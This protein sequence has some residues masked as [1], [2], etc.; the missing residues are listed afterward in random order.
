MDMTTYTKKDM[1]TAA[2][3]PR[4]DQSSKKDTREGS[5]TVGSCETPNDEPCLNSSERHGSEISRATAD[6]GQRYL[7]I[8]TWNVRTM[9]EDGKLHQ[10][11]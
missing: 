6:R 8:A 7:N 9:N 3:P 2:R 1:K 4:V 11:R 10:V 5:T